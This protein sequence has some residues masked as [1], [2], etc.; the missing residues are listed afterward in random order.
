[1]IKKSVNDDAY[2]VEGLKINPGFRL[3]PASASCARMKCIG[4]GSDTNLRA[5]A[6]GKWQSAV[7]FSKKIRVR[8]QIRM[9]DLQSVPACLDKGRGCIPRLPIR[10]WRTYCVR[11]V[12][13]GSPGFPGD[14][15]LL[16]MF[17][18]YA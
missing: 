5:V 14:N 4:V 1:M 15:R 7:F 6:A 13:V 18:R 9:A 17:R 10:S 3:S 12:C 16:R 8:G 11:K 2:S